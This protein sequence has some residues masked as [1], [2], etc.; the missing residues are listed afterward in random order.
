MPAQVQPPKGEKMR[1]LL[2]AAEDI[3]AFAEGSAKAYPKLGL[4]SLVAY[5]RDNLEEAGLVTFEY[6]DMLL[7]NLDLTQMRKIVERFQPD[8]VGISCL[9][10][11]EEI[12]HSLA[13]VVKQACP[14]AL[15]VGGGPYVSSLREAVLRDPNVDVLVFDEGEVT[16]AALLKCLLSGLSYEGVPGIAFR[17]EGEVRT[18]A[19]RPLIE[20]LDQLPIPAFDLVDFD[21]YAA[22]NPHLDVGGRFAPIVTSRGCPFRCVYCHAL[23]G[24]STRFRSVGHVMN[25]FEHLYGEHGV[26]LFYVY[27]DIFNLD[28]ERAKEICRR[29]IASGMD[30]GL[31]FLNGLRADLMDHE[32]ID[33]MLDAG[34]YYIA[35]AVETATPRIQDL[36]KKYNK[37]DLVAD[38]VDY[39][40]QQ[41]GDRCVVATYN[42]IGFPSETEDEIWNTIEFNRS[43]THHIAD[44]AVAIP[45]EHTEMYQMALDVGFKAPAKRTPNYGKDVMMSASEKISPDRLGELVYEFKRAFYDDD[46]KS[47]LLRLAQAPPHTSQSKYLG[48][49]VRGY[50]K[51]SRDFLG[52]TN[53]ALWTG[54]AQG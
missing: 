49:F 5:I 13:G 54:M 43:L 23:H 17:R 7:E 2:T 10:Y 38:A 3:H 37:L 16:F 44:V 50:L 30:I 22:F 11:S 32:L 25:E 36:I 20:N 28:R 34:T 42:M 12:F 46:R 8:L 41:A 19:P 31:D 21:A 39:T 29:I 33:L 27:D 26:R 4:L 15:T 53:A 24:K 47:R 9:S 18:T 45:Q 51:L 35:Y 48:G 14:E 6:H 40:V 1:I 52:D